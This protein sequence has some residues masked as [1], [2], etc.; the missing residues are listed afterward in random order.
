MRENRNETETIDLLQFIKALWKNLAYI[1]LAGLVAAGGCFFY[2]RHFVTP[3][4]EANVLFYVNNSN[5]SIGST[6]VSITS[7]ELS[8]ASS[9]VSTYVAILQSRASMETVIHQS[10]LEYTYEQLRKMVTANAVNSTG[11]FQVTVNSSSPEDARV[12]ANTIA[13]VLPDKISDIVNNSNVKVVDYAITPRARSAPNYTTYALRGL[14]VG[15]V[16]ASAVVV[17]IS[18]FDTIIH[19][20]DF[21]RQTYEAPVLATIPDLLARSSGKYGYGYGYYGSSSQIK[22]KEGGG[23]D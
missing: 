18:Y 14:L 6:S 13:E 16:L 15:I 21:L 2:A 5:I 3:R 20:V 9:L 23:N 22:K 7:G 10:G 17:L 19:D 4:Y 12:L 11:L 8:A 1:L